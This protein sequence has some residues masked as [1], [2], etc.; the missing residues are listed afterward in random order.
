MYINLHVKCPLFLSYLK[1]SAFRKIFKYK[2]FMKILVVGVKMVHE[3]TEAYTD[4]R[5]EVTKQ[6]VAFRNSASAHI[7]K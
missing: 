6:I 5:S 3:D 4:G 1:N 7:N 2:S